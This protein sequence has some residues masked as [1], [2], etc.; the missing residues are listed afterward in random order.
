MKKVFIILGLFLLSMTAPVYVFAIEHLP[1]E[2]YVTL[3]YRKFFPK[4]FP[5]I[6]TEQN[7]PRGPVYIPEI[8][9]TDHTL[10]FLDETDFVLNLYSVDDDEELTLEYSTM[11]P[12]ETEAVMLPSDLS[13]TYVIEVIRGDQ[14]FI[15]EIEL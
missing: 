7:K 1:F 10:Y 9:Q 4:A 15:G 6:Y 2:N 12:A 5:D 13:G 3:T 14:H 11:V 8:G